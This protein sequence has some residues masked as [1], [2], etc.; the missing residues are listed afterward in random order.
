MD[1]C[2]EPGYA[3]VDTIVQSDVPIFTFTGS[4]ESYDISVLFTPRPPF[5]QLSY[6]SCTLDTP[7]VTDLCTVNADSY[8]PATGILTLNTMDKI[9]Y[10]IGLYQFTFGAS[11]GA[12]ATASGSETYTIDFK[13]PC[14]YQDSLDVPT[15][16]PYEYILSDATAT[17]ID[18][19]V[20]VPISSCVISYSYV[21]V[22]ADADTQT[23]LS[24]GFSGFNPPIFQYS[25]D[26]DF[27]GT[28]QVE[29][30]GDVNGVTKTFTFDL[31]LTTPCDLSSFVS[32][33]TEPVPEDA[34]YII[35]SFTEAAPYSL[36]LPNP[37]VT[38]TPI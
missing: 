10:P 20:S 2:E 37:T 13:D 30:T 31:I 21:I 23:K 14:L 32:I 3:F 29:M 5:C 36:P 17:V 27:V 19:M 18:Q 16:G 6:S 24:S 34:S 25:A 15:G 7:G 22:G 38:T 26:H 35:T 11:I 12:G 33:T 8:D 28:Y 9:A 1:P 4:D